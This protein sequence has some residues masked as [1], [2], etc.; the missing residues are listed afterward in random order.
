LK[1]KIERSPVNL[2]L[3]TNPR[4]RDKAINAI[5]GKY[6]GKSNSGVDLSK[7]SQPKKKEGV[8]RA[9]PKKS[10]TI[11]KQ[12]IYCDNPPLAF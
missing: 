2:R 1:N 10:R 12:D 8:N 9:L 4:L 11:S 3:T 6:G 5:C 7:L